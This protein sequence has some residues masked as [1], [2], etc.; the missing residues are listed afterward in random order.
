MK[1]LIYILPFSINALEL[2]TIIIGLYHYKKYENSPLKY[3]LWFLCYGFLTEMA[4]VY[5]S[6]ILK[7]PNHIV[8]NIYALVQF[9]FFLWLFYKYIKTMKY[10]ILVKI[11]SAFIIL[12]FV[13]N[14]LFIQDISKTFQSYFLL[15]G[16]V[17]LM[18]IV[19]LFFIEIMSSDAI[20]KV[21]NL[22]IFWVAVGILLFQLGFLPVFIATK[23]INYSNGPTYGYILVIL[24]FITSLCYSLGFIWTKKNLSY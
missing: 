15:S 11:F 12:F 4:G 19:I 17:L 3:F 23:Y 18:F 9:E 20:L 22:L 8:F 21:K 13:I 10:K 5:I 2:I 16:S 1:Y 6:T 7:L 24:N 14:S